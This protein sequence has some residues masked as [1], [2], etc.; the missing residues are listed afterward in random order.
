MDTWVQCSLCQKWRRVSPTASI[1]KDSPWVCRYNLF[2]PSHNL[3]RHP[4][5]D[6][7]TQE[8]DED[9]DLVSAL[10]S[11]DEENLDLEDEGNHP[12]QP[13]SCTCAL[14][15]ET[16][17][18]VKHWKDL[19]E[20]PDVVGLMKILVDA[21]DATEWQALDAEDNKQFHAGTVID[22]NNPPVAYTPK[23]FGGPH[24]R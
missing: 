1:P 5:E 4:Q 18:A 17:Y 11:S 9:E 13:S 3:C 2:D 12:F 21:V 20:S 6:M 10:L 19:K 8:E 23:R 15:T 14:C 22:L 24:P 7:P 16:N